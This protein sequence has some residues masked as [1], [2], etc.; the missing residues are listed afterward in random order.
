MPVTPSC[1][2]LEP[3]FGDRYAVAYRKELT[4]ASEAS[5]GA[6]GVVIGGGTAVGDVEVSNCRFDQV[7]EGVTTARHFIGRRSHASPRILVG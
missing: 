4:A 3:A 1:I 7:A 5:I 2:L 6:C